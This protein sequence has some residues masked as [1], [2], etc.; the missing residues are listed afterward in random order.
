[1]AF[2]VD[3]TAGELPPAAHVRVQKEILQMEIANRCA[4]LGGQASISS[5]REGIQ[6]YVGLALKD[7]AL[8]AKL[9]CNG[10]F[11]GFVNGFV[12]DQH[13]QEAVRTL[14]EALTAYQACGLADAVV[15][16]L[17]NELDRF[18]LENFGKPT[19]NL[20][21]GEIL[22]KI[23]TIPSGYCH[24]PWGTTFEPYYDCLREANMPEDLLKENLVKIVWLS[25]KSG[26]ILMGEN[27]VS[28]ILEN[29]KRTMESF[30]RIP[31]VTPRQKLMIA[32]V[33]TDLYVGNTLEATQGSFEILQD[34]P[35]ASYCFVQRYTNPY[36]SEEEKQWIADAVL[37]CHYSNPE[38]LRT[39]LSF[40]NEARSLESIAST[41]V[42]VNT[43]GSFSK[44]NTWVAQVGCNMSHFVEDYYLGIDLANRLL[45][46]RNPELKWLSSVYKRQHRKDR[47]PFFIEHY[48]KAYGEYEERDEETGQPTG[49]MVR[50]SNEG[51]LLYRLGQLYPKAKENILRF[52]DERSKSDAP[53]SFI[54][55]PVIGASLSNL[56]FLKASEPH[57]YRLRLFMDVC[58]ASAYGVA[59]GLLAEA[60]YTFSNET[61]AV[62]TLRQLRNYN[63]LMSQLWPDGTTEVPITVRHTFFDKKTRQYVGKEF[64]KFPPYEHTKWDVLG[65]DAELYGKSVDLK[66]LIS[67]PNAPDITFVPLRGDVILDASIIRS[68]GGYNVHIEEH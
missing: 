39:P 4:E 22:K 35:L 52:F 61:Y 62:G 17:K 65:V 44:Y 55:T 26:K 50:Y 66:A 37:R 68:V 11:L 67:D 23:S 48:P 43:L 3:T 38:T 42:V 20:T 49:K 2:N 34:G 32:Q 15:Q 19:A 47:W 12:G 33:W 31:E 54:N 29:V 21:V 5:I 59:V 45:K 16:E 14:R 58:K 24:C 27:V 46:K 64:N 13:G 30:G 56:R 60:P 63:W 51:V 7:P 36:F 10:H 25:S 18:T 28:H 6:T 8:A 53:V 40:A 57:T 41:I 9:V 1:M